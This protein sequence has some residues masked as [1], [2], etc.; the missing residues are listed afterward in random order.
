MFYMTHYVYILKSRSVNKYYIGSSENP[1]RRLRYH[2]IIEKGFTS[3]YR[4]WKIVLRINSNLKQKHKQQ[5][6]RLNLGRVGSII[7]I[8]NSLGEEITT[9]VNSRMT[10]GNHEI[11]WNAQNVPSGMYLYKISAENFSQV[12]KAILLK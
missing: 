2:N 11:T 5:S 8:Y 1:D 4:P 3:R 7:K 10:A 6:E 12:R 9:L